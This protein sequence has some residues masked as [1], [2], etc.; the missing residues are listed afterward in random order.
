MS[1]EIHTLHDGTSIKIISSHDLIKIPVWQGNRI[2]DHNH[3]ENIKLKIKGDIHKLDNGYRIIKYK[4]ED[5][6]RN[7]ITH[8]CIIDGQHRQK[9]LIDYYETQMCEPEFPVV[10]M[11]KIVE[12]EE[13][14]IEYFNALNN[15]RPIQWTDPKLV[16]N[17][18]INAI[19]TAFNT[20]K[21]NQ[22]VRTKTTVRPYLSADKLREVLSANYDKLNL[23][24]IEAFVNRVKEY[25][26]KKI[27]TADIDSTLSKKDKDIIMRAASIKFMLAIDPKLTWIQE[28][29]ST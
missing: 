10:V 16:V 6:G 18:Y 23:S 26:K 15:T 17:K 25:N 12:S 9:V 22:M 5:A 27:S 3:V 21:N 24:E 11:E 19:S 28:L 7:L 14:I 1:K 13:E 2:I 4:E 20:T 8:T 29:L